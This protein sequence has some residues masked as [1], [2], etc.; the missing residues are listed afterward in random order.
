M[1]GAVWTDCYGGCDPWC[2]KK[3]L[4]F[5]IDLKNN[6]NFINL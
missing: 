6:Q 1:N 5:Q 3:I 4:N 2:L